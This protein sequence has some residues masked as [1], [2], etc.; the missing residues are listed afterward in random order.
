M[1]RSLTR[2]LILPGIV[3]ACGMA[4][5]AHAITL[6]SGPDLR[7]DGSK[8][9]RVFG[10]QYGQRSDFLWQRPECDLQHI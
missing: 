10:Y 9:S 2:K 3:F 6:S 8:P 4:G 7:G 1:N 5:T